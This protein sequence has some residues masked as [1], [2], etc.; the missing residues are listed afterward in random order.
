MQEYSKRKQYLKTFEKKIQNSKL[1]H[2][3]K[4][5]E[6]E[7]MRKKTIETLKNVREKKKNQMKIVYIYKLLLKS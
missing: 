1:T 6:K 2:Q 4:V 3:R 7:N 5:L